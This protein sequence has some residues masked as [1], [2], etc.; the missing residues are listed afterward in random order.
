MAEEK[1]FEEK[2]KRWLTKRGAWWI[3]YAP[4][5]LG[6]RAGVPDVLACV[7]G[8][9]YG[10]ELKASDGR[11]SELQKRAVRRIREA[12]GIGVVLYPSGWAAFKDAV[13]KG[14]A[15]DLPFVVR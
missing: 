8:R 7:D 15:D 1:R 13:E 4:T 6:C 11:P 14:S 12:G 2:V 9:F 5:G 10:I 3:K